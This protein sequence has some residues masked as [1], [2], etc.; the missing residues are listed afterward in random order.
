MAACYRVPV[1]GRKAVNLVD[2][3][4][5]VQVSVKEFES[6]KAR[7]P[8]SRNRD[9]TD[10]LNRVG[11]RLSRVVFW[12]M[13]AAEW[14]FVVFDMP[15]QINAFAMAG[16]KVG[17]FSGLFRI[18]KNDD[19][20]ASVIAH[21]IAHVTARHIHERLSQHML[22]QGGGVVGGVALLGTGA[23]SAA[24][25]ALLGVYDLTAGVQVLAFDRGKELE[26]DLIG[27]HYMARAGYNPE[28]AIEVIEQLEAETH[29]QPAP[30][31]WLSTHPTYPQRILQ[32]I[33][34]LPRAKEIYQERG[35]QAAPMIVR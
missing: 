1:T 2:D 19:Q 6:M 5:V 8:R 17:V 12:D 31:P 34:E 4:D 33:D 13:P 23:S 30:S 15:Q 35:R 9:H 29:G 32:L 20:L 24:T 7:Y 18:I 26:A 3:G 27:L 28:A 10:A 25:S 14:E 21:E 11:N 16:G 22:V